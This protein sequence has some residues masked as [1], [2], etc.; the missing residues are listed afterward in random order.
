MK[1][2]STTTFSTSS[3]GGN[4]TV[5]GEGESHDIFL[6]YISSQTASGKMTPKKQ[7][8]NVIHSVGEAGSWS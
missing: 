3:G 1:T 4:F 5:S 7:N 2:V 6:E 8:R